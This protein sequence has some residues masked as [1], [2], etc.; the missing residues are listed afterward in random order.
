MID[1]SEYN[2]EY[3]DPDND[4][5]A[6]TIRTDAPELITKFRKLKELFKDVTNNKKYSNT[7]TWLFIL[8]LAH[9]YVSEMDEKTTEIEKTLE[10]S[11]V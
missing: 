11:V 5:I 4:R 9:R 2:I 7:A 6:H 3:P 8:N 1:L 10:D